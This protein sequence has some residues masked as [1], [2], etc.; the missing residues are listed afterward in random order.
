MNKKIDV[1]LILKNMPVSTKIV[2]EII[3][4]DEVES[5]MD[6]IKGF[7]DS[8]TKEGTVVVAGLQTKGRGRFGRSWISERDKDVLMS[9]LLKPDYHVLRALNMAVSLSI[10]DTIK[11]VADVKPTI[12]WPNDIRVNGFKIAGI[13]IEVDALS[14]GTNCFV[15]IGLNVNSNPNNFSKE[16]EA[17]SLFSERLISFD[18]NRVLSLLLQYLDARYN[19]IGTSDI[20]GEWKNNLD[21]LGKNIEIFSKISDEKYN[22]K[23]IDVANNGDLIVKLT[24][25]SIR[26][27]S[28]GEVTLQQ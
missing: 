3:Y 28:S 22:G 24:N 25:G 9:I 16:F 7:A 26:E 27:F 18:I 6:T 12:K 11:K 8:N 13:L 10:T 2:G 19:S 21:T 5:T 23:A 4:F 17:T 1:D 20:V 15:G 14:S